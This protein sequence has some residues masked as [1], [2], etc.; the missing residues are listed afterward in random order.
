LKYLPAYLAVEPAVP[1]GHPSQLLGAPLGTN[2]GP[3]TFAAVG[4]GGVPLV[5]LATWATLQR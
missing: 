2:G 1:A 4:T 5:L 3:L